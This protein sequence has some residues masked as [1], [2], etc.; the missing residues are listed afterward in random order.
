[1]NFF[2]N[3]IFSYIIRQQRSLL[4]LTL[5]RR[6]YKSK[7][8]L[9]GC[10][11]RSNALNRSNFFYRSMSLSMVLSKGVYYCRYRRLVGQW[12]LALSYTIIGLQ[13]RFARLCD[14]I[15]ANK[16]A[17]LYNALCKVCHETNTR[18][19][20]VRPYFDCFLFLF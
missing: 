19:R 8:Q 4:K 5:I 2:M 7:L 17:R 10:P 15:T 18:D 12:P 3:S 13:P 6:D 1:M 14:S 11:I 16:S 9:V 20:Y